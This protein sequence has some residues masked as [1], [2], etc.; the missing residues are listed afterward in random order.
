MGKKNRKLNTEWLKEKER[1]MVRKKIIK[2]K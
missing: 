1:M 2:I